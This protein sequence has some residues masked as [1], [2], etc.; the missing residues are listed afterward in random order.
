[1]RRRTAKPA[2][3]ARP[4]R[5]PEPVWRLNAKVVA[6]RQGWRG[7]GAGRAPNTDT[8]S[9]YLGTTTEV[10]GL[11]PFVLGSSLP[12]EGVPIGP[13]LLT[14][15]LVCFD[16]AGWTGRLVQNPGVWVMAQPGAG[17]SAIA[18]R[19]CL[20]YASYGHKIIVPG[21][22]KGEYAPLIEKLGGQ[23]VRIGRGR[24]D[25]LNPLDS[26]PLRKR[27]AELPQDRRDALLT[28]INGRRA[29]LLYALL[30]T[31]NGLGRR[32]SAVEATAVGHAVS[33]LSDRLED[34]PVIPDVVRVLREGPK[35]LWAQLLVN[36]A[37]DYN[38]LVREVTSALANLCTGPLAGLFDGPTTQPLDLSAPAVS[39]DLSAL[40][41]AGDHV[42]AA[43]LLATWAY[44][45]G[46]VDS[47]RAL[48]MMDRPLVIPLDE[49]W[50]A[51][52]AGPGM[53][54]AMD[55]MTRLN[56]SKGEVTIFI[57]HSLRDTEALPTA[58][59]RA[60]ALGL[61][62]RCDSLILGALPVSE[63]D[64]VHVQKPL[65]SGERALVASWA[66]PGITGIDGT[67]QRHPGR[68]KYLIKI[69]TRAGSPARLDLTTAEHEM[70]DTDTAMRRRKVVTP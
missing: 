22:V 38:D 57:T 67:N 35:E 28:E 14:H 44:A 59:D 4:A 5:E 68:G 26:G 21:D 50:R 41:T 33:L 48:G 65:T 2:P 3:A 37:E 60:K 20:V 56:R 70:Y 30:A 69:G 66:A 25:R 40:L 62:E 1:M 13:D 64:R 63:L 11:Y 7:R 52:R 58:E 54:D 42:V 47:A 16:P 6:P 53:V 34:D 55:G 23:V 51:L 9:I 43:G 46:A 31:P 17:K 61:M 39:V 29:D 18:K 36:S 19:I 27:A 32:P 24:L 45:Y 12:A 8:G 49:M 15:E 10:A